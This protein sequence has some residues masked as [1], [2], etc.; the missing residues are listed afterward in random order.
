[1]GL[2]LVQVLKKVLIGNLRQGPD[3]LPLSGKAHKARTKQAL[4]A[5]YL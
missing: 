5:H 4:C 3:Q 1:M 2:F